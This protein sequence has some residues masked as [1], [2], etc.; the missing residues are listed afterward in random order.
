M[1]ISRTKTKK[2]RFLKNVK[3]LFV[4]ITDKK[5]LFKKLSNHFNS[6][7]IV[8]FGGEVE[9]RKLKNTLKSHYNG[10]KNL[11][12]IFLTKP[13]KKFIQ[14]GSSLEYGKQSSPHKENFKSKPN[15]NYSRAKFLATKNLMKLYKTKKFPVVIL[16]PYQIYGPYQDA[17]RLIPTVIQSCLKNEKFPCSHGLQYRDFLYIEDF[18]SFVFK[19]LIIKKLNGEIFNIGYGKAYKVKNIINSIKKSIKRGFPEFGKI[20]LRND[21]NL[22]TYPSIEKAKR[23]I[24]WKPNLKFNKG[25]KKTINYYKNNKI[26]E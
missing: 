23:L 4:D 16:R 17:N 1:S 24:G 25:I 11:A 20:K 19:V 12:S 2:I 13:I 8:N 7:Y 3:Y 26:N 5:K 14:V 21:E 10:S 22:A 9:H 6:E 15:S 18:V